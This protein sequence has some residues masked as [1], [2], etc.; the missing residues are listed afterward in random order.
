MCMAWWCADESQGEACP[1][2]DCH[3]RCIGIRQNEV[4]PKVKSTA[5]WRFHPGRTGTDRLQ[6][7]QRS[8][9]QLL[10]GCSGCWTQ[11]IQETKNKRLKNCLLLHIDLTSTNHD[12]NLKLL[13]H[14]SKRTKRLDVITLYTSPDEWRQRILDRLHTSD[15]PSL[16]AAFITLSAKIS[17]QLSNFL[18]HREYKKW[19]RKLSSYKTRGNCMINTF[20]QSFLKSIPPD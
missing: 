18:Y 12:N 7:K 1:P 10:N 2:R 4:D 19:L 16:K 17:R 15:E 3:R 13:R 8:S 5:P 14:I 20:E 6:L 11:W 9:A